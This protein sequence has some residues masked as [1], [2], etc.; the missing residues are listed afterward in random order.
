ME[1]RV[2]SSLLKQLGGKHAAENRRIQT[3]MDVIIYVYVNVLCICICMCICICICICICTQP[4]RRIQTCMDVIIYVY[5]NVLCICICI[6]ICI[7]TQP[8]RRILYTMSIH[9]N[10]LYHAFNA[11]VRVF[12]HTSHFWIMD[13]KY[14]RKCSQF[15]GIS[16]YKCTIE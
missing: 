11:W 7:C 15:Q 9:L 1:I 12:W 6:C 10:A 14:A 2:T 8:N 13:L 3:C 4:N 5:V 16:H